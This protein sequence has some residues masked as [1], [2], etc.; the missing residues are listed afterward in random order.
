MRNHSLASF[1]DFRCANCHALV[2]SMQMLQKSTIATTVPIVCGRVTSIYIPQVTAS[3]L[4]KR[5]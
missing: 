4:V 2:S 1:G 5:R 3:Q